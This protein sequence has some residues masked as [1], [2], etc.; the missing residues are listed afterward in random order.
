MHDTKALSVKDIMAELGC[1]VDH[2]R[3]IMLMELPHTDI[4][5]AGAKRPTWRCKRK[6]FD[7][8]LATREEASGNDKLTEFSRQ[9]MKAGGKP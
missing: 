2:A 6:D 1:K 5:V 7:R 3:T 8:W 9:Y 4:S